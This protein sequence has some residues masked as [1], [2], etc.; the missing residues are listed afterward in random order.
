MLASMAGLVAKQHVKIVPSGKS[1][2]S[3]VPSPVSL[4][5]R[6]ASICFPTT[7][8]HSIKSSFIGWIPRAYAMLTGLTI[9]ES[10]GT[11]AFLRVARLDVNT[12]VIV[13]T[14]AHVALCG[15]NNSGNLGTNLL[16][17]RTLPEAGSPTSIADHNITLIVCRLIVVKNERWGCARSLYQSSIRRVCA[18]IA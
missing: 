13:S 17:T 11:A 9:R 12:L 16:G 5:M 6:R 7:S 15:E 1:I 14:A 2:W 18:K 4:K 8:E 10:K 3:S